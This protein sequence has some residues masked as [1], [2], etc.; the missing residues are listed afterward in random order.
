MATGLL[1]DKNLNFVDVNFGSFHHSVSFQTFAPLMYH[2]Y[3]VEF[4][5]VFFQCSMCTI[6][7]SC[8]LSNS[9]FL[10]TV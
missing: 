8:L 5:Y 9:S 10:L 6:S 1:G 3:V 2:P 7:H 4:L